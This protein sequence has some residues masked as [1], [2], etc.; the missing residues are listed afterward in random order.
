[1]QLELSPLAATDLEA[2]G[3]YIAQDSPLN[4]VRFIAEL[5]AQ[6]QRIVLSP[7]GYRARPE[8]G[9]NPRSCT[10]GNFV[11]FFRPKGDLV[12]IERILHGAMDLRPDLI[13]PPVQ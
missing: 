1:M 11:I 9:D 10:Y 4:A 5:R 7:Q 8:L 3:D 2:I 13:D 12:R 6:C